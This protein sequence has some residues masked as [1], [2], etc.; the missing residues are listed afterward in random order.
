MRARTTALSLG[1]LIVAS[2]GLAAASPISGSVT[3]DNHY[4]LYASHNGAVSFIGGN[5]LGAGGSPGTYNWSQAESWSYDTGDRVI[6][7]AWSDHAVAQGLLLDMHLPNLSLLSGDSSWRVIAT[8]LTLGDGSPAPGA[9][10]VGQFVA[11]ADANNLWELPYVGGN[12]GVAPWGTVAGISG[13]AQWMWRN[14]QSVGDPLHGGL[15]AGE[16]LIFSRSVPAP[17]AL[18]VLGFAGLAIGWRRR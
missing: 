11:A 1:V 13:N 14:V 15:D 12:N 8:G 6:I 4:A 10:Q 3:A 5:E 9:G 2:A 17:S 16:Y 7:A 18:A